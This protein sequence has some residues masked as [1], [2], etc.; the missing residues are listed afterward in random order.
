MKVAI[1][2][3][4]TICN[5]AV[6]AELPANTDTITYMEASA[7][8]AAGYTRQMVDPAVLRSRLRQRVATEYDTLIQKTGLS[9][10]VS[11][12]TV[13]M[14]D[15]DRQNIEGLSRGMELVGKAPSDTCF[16]APDTFTFHDGQTRNLLVSEVNELFIVYMATISARYNAH[17]R[18]KDALDAGTTP[19]RADY[20]A[21]GLTAKDVNIG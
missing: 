11:W 12:G 15:R 18:V 9:I 5:I 7:A 8:I 1:I 3:N 20:E 10:T 21:C 2:E 16:T 17:K 14:S 6:Y 13:L 19:S 4:G